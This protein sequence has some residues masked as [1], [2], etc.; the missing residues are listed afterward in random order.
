[1]SL[2]ASSQLLSSSD[3]KDK[4]EGSPSKLRLKQLTDKLSTLQYG[5]NEEQQ[6]R[7]EAFELKVKS[8]EE[9]ISRNQV[10]NGTKFKVTHT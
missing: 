5:A 9:K 8:V 6:V 2:N 4:T 1:M 10:A 7:K 3:R